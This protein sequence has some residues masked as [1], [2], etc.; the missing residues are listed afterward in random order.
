LLLAT[1]DDLFR[2]RVVLNFCVEVIDQAAEVRCY[3]RADRLNSTSILLSPANV[4]LKL[5][6]TF[7]GGQGA[8]S[9]KMGLA[10]TDEPQT[11]E[12]TKVISGDKS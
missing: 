4:T 1:G 8:D 7:V 10:S 2:V 11:L 3:K 9:L 12:T 6:I 5:L